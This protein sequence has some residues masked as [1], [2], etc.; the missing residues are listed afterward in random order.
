MREFL[1]RTRK[2]D[3]HRRAGLLDLLQLNVVNL[4]SGFQ[5]LKTARRI[6]GSG[7]NG[8]EC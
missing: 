3:G 1:R 8:N 6:L 4:Q 7:P 2:S 5:F